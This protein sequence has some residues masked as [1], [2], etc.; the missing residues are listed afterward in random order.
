MPHLFETLQ[1]WFDET[2][3]SGPENM[4]VDEW[5]LTNAEVPLLRVYRWEEN[6]GSLGYFG[7]ISEARDTFPGVNWVRRWTGGGLV[8][9]RDD[10]TYTLVVPIHERLATQRGAESY[11]LIHE[12]LGNVLAAEGAGIQL[13]VGSYATGAAAC[14]ENP[15]EH[16]LVDGQGLKRAGAGQRRTRAGLLHQGSVSGSLGG[17]ASWKRAEAFGALLARDVQVYQQNAGD[18]KIGRLM[19]RYLEKD[20]TGRR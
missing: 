6:W 2:A 13:S 5:L 19:G 1:L 17:A 18:E 10:W 8:D 11:R 9:H 7:S 15:V 4:A 3:R 12:V 14:F 20:W 16:D